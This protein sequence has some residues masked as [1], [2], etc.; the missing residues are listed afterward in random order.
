MRYWFVVFA[1]LSMSACA[2]LDTVGSTVTDAQARY[3]ASLEAREKRQSEDMRQVLKTIESV[4]SSG[5]STSRVVGLL[6]LD[7][8]SNGVA[9][10]RMAQVQMPPQ[11]G[12]ITAAFKA[13]APYVIPGLQ[14]WASDRAGSRALDQAFGNMALIGQIAGQ[15]QRDPLVVNA[16]AAPD[17]IIVTT[18]PPLVV[19]RPTPFIVDQP[20]LVPTSG[21]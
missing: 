17:P 6:M 4:S 7:R 18:P 9:S 14:I 8:I 21:G 10:A 2:Q 19:D 20:I 5:D 3:L 1:A 12:P 11:D 15:I 16:P 13:V